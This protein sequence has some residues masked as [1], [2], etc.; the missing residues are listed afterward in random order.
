MH[1]PRPEAEASSNA[2]LKSKG[3]Q[4]AVTAPSEHPAWWVH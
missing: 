1:H 2:L 4:Y 3:C